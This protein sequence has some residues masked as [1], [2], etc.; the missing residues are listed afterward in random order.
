MIG[1]VKWIR[2]DYNRTIGRDELAMKGDWGAKD[3]WIRRQ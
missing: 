1:E 2:I 3:L